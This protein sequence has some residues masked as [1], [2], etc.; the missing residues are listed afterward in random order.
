MIES[1]IAL[2]RTCFW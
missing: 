2:M 1:K